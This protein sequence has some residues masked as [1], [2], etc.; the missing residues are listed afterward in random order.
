MLNSISK[1]FG[2]IFMAIS[3]KSTQT[4]KFCIPARGLFYDKKH[5]LLKYGQV[6]R[7]PS[8]GGKV[9][10]ALFQEMEKSA[11]TLEKMPKLW[12]SVG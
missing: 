11:L 4:E 9:Y 7:R 10:P 12:S 8:R 6:F 2:T 1:F 5:N 3:L